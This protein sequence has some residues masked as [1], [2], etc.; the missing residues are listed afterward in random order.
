[1]KR[2]RSVKRYDCS[3]IDERL[4]INWLLSAPRN[5]PK[6]GGEI[7]TQQVTAF[8]RDHGWRVDVTTLCDM[9][10][11][12]G[13]NFLWANVAFIW[14]LLVKGPATMVILEDFYMHPWLFLFNWMARLSKRHYVVGIVQLFYHYQQRSG[15]LNAVDRLVAAL[16]LRPAHLVFANS[17]TT[18]CECE[19]LGVHRDRIVVVYPGC[20]FA[21]EP[22]DSRRKE[23]DDNTVRLLTIGNYDPR[24]GL[25]HLLE[26]M[27]MVRQRE[28]DHFRSLVLQIAGDP[29]SNT[30][31]TQK[32]RDIIKIG[33]LEANVQ[34]LGWCNRQQIKALLAHSDIFVFPS[35]QEG[36]GM[37]L[38]EAMHYGLP[39]IA[40][41]AGAVPELVNDGVNGC[42]V[43][44]GD[45]AGLAEA[46][47]HLSKDTGLCG[48]L[49]RNG[50][51]F[52]NRFVHSW[53]KVGHEFHERLV[54]FAMG[55]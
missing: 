13:K 37:V 49:G 21:G 22:V 8:L 28:P 45:A 14:K 24:K 17:Q 25:H 12:P 35:V 40:C 27:V 16:F 33:G 53:S 32:L 46:I 9:N 2:S 19:R 50:Q 7:Y 55:V 26:A 54:T 51:V 41:R 15:I 48:L 42:L 5:N 39:I 52:S 4:H 30:T 36:F 3:A 1:M 34:L 10:P 11:Y 44:P 31:Y 47:V 6:T 38:A 20:D 43:E 29:C 18:A 23:P